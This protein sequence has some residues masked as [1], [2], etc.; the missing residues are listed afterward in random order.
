MIT[1]NRRPVEYEEG[2]TVA[3]LLD[4]LNYKWPMLI[5]RVN[6]RLIDRKDFADTPVADGDEVD[7]IHM[8]SGG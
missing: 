3:S 6:G 8:M 1:V 2:M 7:A 5:L 4:R